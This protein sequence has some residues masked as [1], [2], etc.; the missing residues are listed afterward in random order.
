[1]AVRLT[2]L[3]KKV[4]SISDED[5]H[6]YWSKSHPRIFLSVKIVQEKVVKYN[7]FHVNRDVMNA[8]ASHGLPAAEYDGGVNLWA[9]SVEDLMAVFQDD[10]YNRVVV[11]DENSFLQRHEAKMMVGYDE[12]K[13]VDGKVVP[14]IGV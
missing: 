10:E 13:W 3:I 2:I 7:Q 5:F 4:E 6:I 9:N 11:P 8:L 14:D 1:M 12:D